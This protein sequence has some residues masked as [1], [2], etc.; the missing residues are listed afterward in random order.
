MVACNARS[1]L[2]F[3]SRHN[4]LGDNIKKTVLPVFELGMKCTPQSMAFL[5][6]M[7][8]QF[9]SNLFVA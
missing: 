9:L 4:L 8:L 1:K 7:L 5:F 2:L 6:V 3:F